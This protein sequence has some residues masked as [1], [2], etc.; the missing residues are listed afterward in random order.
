MLKR[1]KLEKVRNRLKEL[2]I[3][4]SDDPRITIQIYERDA[5]YSVF[6]EVYYKGVSEG[7]RVEKKYLERKVREIIN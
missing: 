4:K 3:D 7:R 2:L 6:E 5:L 1:F